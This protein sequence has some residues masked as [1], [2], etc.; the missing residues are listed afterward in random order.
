[1]TGF[2][3]K[4]KM[5]G[6]QKVIKDLTPETTMKELLTILS[7]ASDIPV[8]KL[9]IL[10]GFPPKVLDITDVNLPITACG[11]TSGDTLILEERAV[12]ENIATSLN[13]ITPEDISNFVSDTYSNGVLMKHIVPADNSCLFTSIFFV[14]NGKID[15][16]GNSSNWMRNLIAE[17][18]SS[19][20]INF[21]EAILGKPNSEY[22]KWIQDEKSWGGA[23]EIAIMSDYYG[24]EIAVVDTINAII[25]RFGEDKNYPHR[26][27]LLFDGIHYDPLY[28]EPIEVLHR[29]LN[30]IHLQLIFVYV[31]GWQQANNI[32]IDR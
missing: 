26:V 4:L 15:E 7:S 25:N 19:D 17:T 5:K 10:F 16:T 3:I 13:N 30:L 31:L 22:C 12:I 14:L 29:H 1:M 21:S 11:I 28:L 6:G 9:H 18:V 23:I 24:I 27:F 2:A 32:S 8:N 20:T